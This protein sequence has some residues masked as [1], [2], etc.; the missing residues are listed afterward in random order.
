MQRGYLLHV[1]P[2]AE[3][4]AAPL[5]LLIVLHG[6][7]GRGEGMVRLTHFNDL[8]DRETF[9]VAYPDG[10]NHQW[11]DGRETAQKTDDVAFVRALLDNIRLLCSMDPARVYV[12]GMSNGGFMAGRLDLEMGDVFAAF[13]SVSA[14]L[15]QKLV[16]DA[17]A[18]RPISG[19]YILG[20][21][22]PIVPYNGGEIEIGQGGRVASKN[23]VVDFWARQDGCA[24][25]P[26]TTTLPDTDPNDGCRV[27]RDSYAAG[28]QGAELV[29]YSVEGGGHAWPGGLQYLPKMMIG[30]TNRDIDASAVIWDFFKRHPLK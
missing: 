15:P 8:A 9:L 11:N 28:R 14:T 17:K 6:G 22:D 10:L 2:H 26:L 20:T 13:A 30:R 18:V 19:L 25:L 16:H 24:R 3:R 4:D 27:R 21:T 5:P 1:P 12:T 7:G 23:Q 29:V